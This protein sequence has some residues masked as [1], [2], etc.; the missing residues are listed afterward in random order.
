MATWVPM[1][2]Q[3]QR[4]AVVQSTGARSFIDATN[5]WEQL[6]SRQRGSNRS[7]QNSGTCSKRTLF[8]HRPMPLRGLYLHLRELFTPDLCVQSW[9]EALTWMHVAVA[10]KTFNSINVQLNLSSSAKHHSG[11]TKFSMLQTDSRMRSTPILDERAV[12]YDTQKQGIMAAI[13]AS[14]HTCVGGVGDP[15]TAC[16]RTEFFS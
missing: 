7:K 16:L 11:T 5:M 4:C 10:K 1:P 8:W 6:L 13:S 3:S 9:F 2:I 12:Q 15:T 14:N